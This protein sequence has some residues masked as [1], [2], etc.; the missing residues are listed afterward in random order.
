MKQNYAFISAIIILHLH[1]HPSILGPAAVMDLLLWN[2]SVRCYLNISQG[3]L[4][5]SHWR[6]YGG[7]M[8]MYYTKVGPLVMLLTI[9]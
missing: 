5:C 6:V 1:L 8:F 3:N 4:K 2:N 9:K 7:H